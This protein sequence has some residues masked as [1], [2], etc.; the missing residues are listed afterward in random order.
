MGQPDHW[1]V[2]DIPLAQRFGITIT[3]AAFV[4]TVGTTLTFTPA[5]TAPPA[6]VQNVNSVQAW[7]SGGITGISGQ[8]VFAMPS[9][10]QD[11]SGGNAP[12]GM[13]NFAWAQTYGM[14]KVIVLGH[15]GIAGS[16]DTTYPSPGQFGAVDNETFLLNCIKY[17]N[18]PG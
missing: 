11:V 8:A 4:P 16:D 6:L 15:S 7:D 12:P 5:D 13:Y 14:G 10:A 3:P 2:N 1:D 9:S 18:G 17:L